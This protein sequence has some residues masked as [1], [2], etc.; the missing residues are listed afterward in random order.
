MTVNDNLTPILPHARSSRSGQA[1]VEFIV[2]LVAVLVLF[3]GLL[4]VATLTK[5]HTDTMVEARRLAAERA[6]TDLDA[7]SNPD[8][9]SNWKPG[10]DRKPYT[11][12]DIH[13]PADPGSFDSRIVDR[14]AEDALGWSIIDFI[15]RNPLADMHGSGTPASE[16]GLVS[17]SDTRTVDLLPAVQ[18]LIYDRPRINVR[19]TVWMTQTKGLY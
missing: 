11:R 10:T 3:A 8:Y 9:I 1:I 7:A 4:Q 14:A 19:C 5:K 13:S 6:M 17:G 12:D 18:D 16:F 2:G 15:P